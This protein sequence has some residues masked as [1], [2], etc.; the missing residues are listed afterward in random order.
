MTPGVRVV[1]QDSILDDAKTS[2]RMAALFS[3][4]M[5]IG[6]AHGASYKEWEYAECLQ[7]AG[8]R[9]VRRLRMPGPG[10]LRTARVT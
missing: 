3:L 9:D 7:Q 5:L 8:F 4:N 1:I 2:P 10:S 6:A